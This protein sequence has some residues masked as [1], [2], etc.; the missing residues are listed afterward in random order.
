MQTIEEM[1]VAGRFPPGT[2]LRQDDLS[3]RFGVSRTPIREALRQLA[4]V[5]LVSFTPN[6]GVRV[7]ALDRDDWA[8]TYMARAALEGAATEVAAGR[9]TEAQLADLNAANDDFARQTDLL[10]QLGRSRAD[11]NQAAY[12][13][14]AAND[15]FHAGI[16]RAARLP[17]IEG[18]IGG[19]RRVFSG[20]ASWAPGSAA[21][22]LYETNLRQHE[23]IKAALAAR[24]G[25]AARTLMEAHILDSWT[26]LQAVLDESNEPRGRDH[27]A[28]RAGS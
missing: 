4:A 24:N 7:R 22:T 12:A 25:T 10:R 26:H 5:G 21:D 17:V 1:I 11:R 9:I 2:V 8:Q 20:E 6:R 19:L 3:H 16:V 23:A 18:L 27:G 28:A 14:V 15:R 13:W